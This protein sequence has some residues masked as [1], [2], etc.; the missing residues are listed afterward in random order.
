MFI[1]MINAGEYKL[2]FMKNAIQ[3]K[4]VPGVFSKSEKLAGNPLLF[5]FGHLHGYMFCHSCQANL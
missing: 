5:L 3:Y 1:K 4:L 2:Y